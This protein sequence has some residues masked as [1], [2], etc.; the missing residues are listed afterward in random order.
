MNNNPAECR[1][2]FD[3]TNNENDP[4]IVP[5]NCD[6]SSRYIHRNCLETWR[7][8]N[9]NNDAYTACRE[10]LY[11]YSIEFTYP[12]EELACST[13]T[14]FHFAKSTTWMTVN[15]WVFMLG[16]FTRTL[17]KFIPHISLFFLPTNHTDKQSLQEMLEEDSLLEIFYYYAW[18]IF[19][20]TI[21]S[22]FL[23][24]GYIINKQKR[25]CLIWKKFIAKYILYLMGSTHFIYIFFLLK[26]GDINTGIITFET[27]INAETVLSTVNY[28]IFINLIYHYNLLITN[29]NKQNMGYVENRENNQTVMINIENSSEE[30]EEVETTDVEEEEEETIYQCL[31]NIV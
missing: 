29:I 24:A 12:Q 6:G 30:A 3:D 10:C 19:C 5:C 20:F 16:L 7:E 2:C 15:I 23:F 27:Y 18:L 21:I 1:I 11:N 26:N 9:I 4:L 14:L 22:Y 8:T 31:E 17:G 28:M 25:K 13:R